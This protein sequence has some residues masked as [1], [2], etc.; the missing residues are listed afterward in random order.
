MYAV[1]NLWA[2]YSDDKGGFL[3]GEGNVIRPE[4]KEN[5]VPLIFASRI[6]A[7]QA[8]RGFCNVMDVRAIEVYISTFAK[9]V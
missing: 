2:I 3:T 5:R 7:T 8:A 9:E 1:Y 6:D 4:D